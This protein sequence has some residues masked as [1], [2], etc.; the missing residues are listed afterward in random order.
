MADP[1]E[2]AQKLGLRVLS[3]PQGPAP[4]TSK[5]Q[6]EAERL[7]LKLKSTPDLPPPDIGTGGAFM[8]GVEDPYVGGAQ[9]LSHIGGDPQKADEAVREREAKL[10]AGGIGEHG[11][12]RAAGQVVGT[13]PAMAAAGPIAA[14]GFPLVGGAVGGAL[15][16]GA[17]PVTG[18]DYWQQKGFDTAMGAAFGAAGGIPG[19][20]A[21]GATGEAQRGLLERGVQLTPGQ[22]TSSRLGVIRRAEQALMSVPI[23]GSFIRDAQGRSIRSFNIAT[24]NKS[25]EP[26]GAKLPSGVEAGHEA[27]RIARSVLDDA[28]HDVLPKMQLSM[29]DRLAGDL[30]D[31]RFR[32]SSMGKEYSEQYD[33][34]MKNNLGSRFVDTGSISGDQLKSAESEIN[35]LAREY[36]ASGS[37]KD[38]ELGRFLEE[39]R[40]ALR[41]AAMEQNPNEAPFLKKVDEAYAM[42]ARIR[43][44]GNKAT[45]EGVFTPADLLGAIR[46]QDKSVKHGRFFEG[47]ALMQDWGEW[48]QAVLPTKLA[49]SGT[50]ERGAF[51]ASAGEAARLLDRPE[52]L[53]GAAAVSVPYTQIGQK[54]T[55][56]VA[57]AGPR[58]QAM[59][60]YLSSLGGTASVPFTLPYGR[61]E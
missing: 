9:F 14:A 52:I 44:A 18:K 32:T 11:L 42:F 36:A 16:A 29:T 55:S 1:H 57:N 41:T 54:V 19:K 47:D 4:D 22:A 50:I 58:R 39:A 59:G 25:L 8:S 46:S 40:S 37:P 60:K 17:M 38:R 26:I 20:V 3:G 28:Y 43:E 53:A 51:I 23:L 61:S 48:A 13:I 2:E 15:S 27:N 56:A 10:T 12:A 45:K 7:G 49:D 24:I 33:T 34:I 6:A 30:S 35:R 31:I 5:A 21:G